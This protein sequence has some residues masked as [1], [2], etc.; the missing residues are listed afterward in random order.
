M[1]T[2]MA[3]A[4]AQAAAAAE[5]AAAVAASASASEGVAVEIPARVVGLGLTNAFVARV[6]AGAVDARFAITTG[7]A[8]DG[9]GCGAEGTDD[10]GR[11]RRCAV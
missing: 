2:R 5:Q 1:L 10:T 3:S 6:A 11:V 9:T 8:V 7:W 4:A